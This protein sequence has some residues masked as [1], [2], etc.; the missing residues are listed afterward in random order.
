MIPRHTLMRSLAVLITLGVIF[1]TGGQTHA[2]QNWMNL[3]YVLA[4][5]HYFMALPYSVRQAR[6][7]VASPGFAFKTMGL[8][9]AAG[10]F[11]TFRWLPLVYYFGI[12]H[13]FNEAYQIDQLTREKQHPSIRNLRTSAVCLYLLVYL[14]LLRHRA[15]LEYIR[16]EALA[17]ALAC[18][19]G[20]YFYFLWRCRRLLNRSEII[21]NCAA[22]VVSF[23][24]VTLSFFYT[25]QF[26][27]IVAYHFIYWSLRPIP[28]L[29]E[30]SRSGLA[31]YLGLTG[32]VFIAAF[33][34]SPK[35]L[36]PYAVEGS[37]FYKQF[38][39]WSYLHITLS[40]IVSD[41]HPR[42]IVQFFRPSIAHKT[43]L[44]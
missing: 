42:W 15:E 34:L 41:F 30:K 38:I 23:L 8:L 12:H 22:E 25:V 4:F 36:F 6:E 16:F 10:L 17:A 13:A 18:G 20:V 31:A 11:V 43:Q 29:Y 37:L 40:F 19:Y 27:F 2:P 24:A 5:V 14:F 28:K 1:L 21:D 32:I 33:A 9:G 26:L 7:A 3:V 35:G 44:L 39:F